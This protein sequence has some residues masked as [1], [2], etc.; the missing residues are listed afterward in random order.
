MRIA[1]ASGLCLVALAACTRGEPPARDAFPAA[2]QHHTVPATR[3]IALVPTAP[4]EPIDPTFKGC[5]G[6]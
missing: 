6:G 1:V 2:A 5:E 3:S 4:W